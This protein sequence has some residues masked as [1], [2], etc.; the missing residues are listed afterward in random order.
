MAAEKNALA[1]P[2]T[3]THDE[4][5]QEQNRIHEFFSSLLEHRNAQGGVHSNSSVMARC[6]TCKVTSGMLVQDSVILLATLFGMLWSN[7]RALDFKLAVARCHD[8]R[9]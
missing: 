9:G 6:D 3:A 8:Y 5:R 7:L 1:S 4:K 2:T